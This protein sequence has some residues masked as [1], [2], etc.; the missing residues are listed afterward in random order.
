MCVRMEQLAR[1]FPCLKDC[2]AIHPWNGIKLQ[3]WAEE[4]ANMFKLTH[5]LLSSVSFLL[6]LWNPAHPWKCAPFNVLDAFFSW[7]DEHRQAFLN[8]AQDPWWP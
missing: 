2:P 1:S 8:W 5:N 7:D 6:Y 4:Q 3:S